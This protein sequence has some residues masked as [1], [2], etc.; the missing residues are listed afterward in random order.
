MN[1]FDDSTKQAHHECFSSMQKLL[2]D[3]RDDK[4][5]ANEARRR[6][7]SRNE[8]PLASAVEEDGDDECAAAGDD[9]AAAGEGEIPEGYMFAN[10][11]PPEREDPN[12]ENPSLSAS[13][14]NVDA[15][16]K[17]I[18][19]N[20]FFYDYLFSIHYMIPIPLFFSWFLF[21]DL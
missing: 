11:S 18:T 13:H 4:I 17:S 20:S 2:V 6:A 8:Q 1:A 15:H 3:A 9:S 12:D 5:A 14:D 21:S 7:R 16:D 10:R 19:S